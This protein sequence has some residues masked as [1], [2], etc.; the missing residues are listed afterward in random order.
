M[1]SDKT[2]LQT[3]IESQEPILV[4]EMSPPKGGD[5]APVRAT[6]NR[7]AGK[8]HAIG[9]SDN[10]DGARMSALAA[11]ALVA[12][13]GVE[14]ILHAV[15]RDRN[16]VALV[17]NCLGAQALGIR[18]ILCTSGTH[19]TLGICRSAK[20]VFDIDSVQLLDVAARLGN[21]G[22]VVGD[23]RFDP[24]G[25]FC[26][27]AVGAPFADP[28]ELQLMRLAKK[29]AAGAQFIITQPVYDLDRFKSWWQQVTQ[30]GLREKVAILAGIRPLLNAE[31]AKVYA[32]SRPNPMIPDAVLKRLSSAGD[33]AA[34]R[35]GGIALAVE[36]VQQL[37]AL[38][39]VRGFEI[40]TDRDEEA[41]L[42][43]LQQSGLEAGCRAR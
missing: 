43:I 8:V 2:G 17:A 39:G 1:T 41:A 25:P 26:L 27:G 21:N 10:R 30:Q 4:V 33:P 38:G 3:R 5:P 6:A 22:S 16:R 13:E 20:N 12:A 15:T 24:A 37:S 18:N 28:P 34:Q 19:Q 35:A 32:A 7:F 40:R 42:E 36:T 23:E 29:V 11:A 9:V 31:D 14:P